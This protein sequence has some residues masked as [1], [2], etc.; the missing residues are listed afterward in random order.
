MKAN[1]EVIYKLELN[2]KEIQ[3]V[4][5]CLYAFIDD[6]LNNHIKGKIGLNKLS[7]YQ[8][9]I[10]GEINMYLEDDIDI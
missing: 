6:G 4:K 10:L 9:D 2:Q 1:K 3:A 8:L 5:D 7:D